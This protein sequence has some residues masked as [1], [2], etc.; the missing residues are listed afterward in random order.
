MQL[1]LSGS[2]YQCVRSVMWIN[3]YQFQK[4][5]S[6]MCVRFYLAVRQL[7][8]MLLSTCLKFAESFLPPLSCSLESN[9]PK[10]DV[11]FMVGNKSRMISLKAKKANSCLNRN[12]PVQVLQCHTPSCSWIISQIDRLWEKEPS[13][14]RLEQSWA[15]LKHWHTRLWRP[16]KQ[17]L[18]QLVHCGDQKIALLVASLDSASHIVPQHQ[19]ECAGHVT[20][21]HWECFAILYWDI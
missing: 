14:H 12:Q 16:G 18:D 11:M 3:Y 9:M 5:H 15:Y 1:Q 19:N 2:S 21:R 13:E 20:W 17:W 8:K 7:R 4:Q 6:K 10:P